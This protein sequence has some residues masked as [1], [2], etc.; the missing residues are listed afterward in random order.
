MLISH[1]IADM[2][3]FGKTCNW[4]VRQEPPEDMI[5]EICSD[6][7]R[8]KHRADGSAGRSSREVNKSTGSESEAELKFPTS[9]L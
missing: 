8:A 2:R 5:L 7:E 6:S 4:A 1:L 9:S 3:W